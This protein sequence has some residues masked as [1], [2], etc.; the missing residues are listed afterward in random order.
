MARSYGTSPESLVGLTEESF[1]ANADEVTHFY[2]EDLDVISNCITKLLPEVKVTHA[3]GSIHWYN[4]VKI[5]L[6][7]TDNSCNKVLVV[8]TDITERKR[9]DEMLRMADRRKDQFL[10]MLAHE[11]RNPLAPIRNAV[12]LLKMQQATDPKLAWSCNVIDRQVTHMAQLLDDLLDVARIMQGKISLKVERFR[13]YRH[14][15]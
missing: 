11:L 15:E 8:A 1:N 7:D 14:C 5:P 2:Q 6:I 12:Q 4:T 9:A 13:A 10:A 3:D